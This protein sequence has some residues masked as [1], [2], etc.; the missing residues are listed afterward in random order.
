MLPMSRLLLVFLSAILLFAACS[1]TN[2]VF[3]RGKTSYV[4]QNDLSPKDS[5]HVM[6]GRV[7]RGMPVRHAIAALGR[8]HTIDT[9]RTE[10]GTKLR[11][12]YRAQMTS[13]QQSMD[14][15]FVYALD[16]KVTRWERLNRI[17][18]FEAYQ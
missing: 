4:R 3:K 6:E 13:V 7:Y 10:K 1:T 8:P 11:L 5:A 12:T 15:A 14:L 18:R 9:T 17:P 16:E 2:T